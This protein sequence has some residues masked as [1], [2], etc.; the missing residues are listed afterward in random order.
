MA[1]AALKNHITARAFHD[2]DHGNEKQNNDAQNV[3]N[4]ADQGDTS[5]RQNEKQFIVHWD[6][7]KGLLEP[8]EITIDPERKRLGHKS[9]SLRI[10]D[11]NLIKTLGTGMNVG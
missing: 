6:D 2:D 7:Q 9:S 11:F 1:T 10:E 8:K 4:S 5:P 3:Q